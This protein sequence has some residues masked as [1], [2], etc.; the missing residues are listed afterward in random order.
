MKKILIALAVSLCWANVAHASTP[1]VLSTMTDAESIHMCIIASE[2]AEGVMRQRQNK[3]DMATAYSVAATL[4]GD[5]P[6]PF[7]RSYRQLYMS[8]IAQAYE[9]PVVQVGEQREREI[10]RFK[11]QALA[12][13]VRSIP[14]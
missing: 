3:D 9:V 8:Y 10:K 5:D 7:A 13:C 2:G 6:S 1:N 14:N 12:R 11:D 4:G